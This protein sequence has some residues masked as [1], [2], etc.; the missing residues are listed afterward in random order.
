M[1]RA[2]TPA[3]A[4]VPPSNKLLTEAENNFCAYALGGGHR[5]TPEIEQ[6]I[7]YIT[8]KDLMK[9]ETWQYINFQPHLLPQVRG[10]EVTIYATCD[11]DFTNE[12]VSSSTRTSTR[13]SPSSRSSR[14][15]CP[16]RPSGS[17]ARTSAR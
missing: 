14:R 2:A 5:H 9:P 16:F 1:P 15:A 11:R 10:I 13:M 4:A 8:G 3:Q 6:N 7:A 12:E 17:T